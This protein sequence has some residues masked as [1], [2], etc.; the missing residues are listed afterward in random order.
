M[1]ILDR[2]IGYRVARGY[3]LVMAICVAVRS[4]L[5]LVEEL[6]QVGNGQYTLREVFLFIVLMLPSWI[7]EL[8]PVTALLGGLIGLGELAGGRELVAMQTSGVSPLRIGWSVLRAGGLLLLAAMGLQEFVAPPMQQLALTRQTQA[9]SGTDAVRT[10]QGFWSRDGR[11]VM[12][13]RRILHGQIPSD[14]DIYQF[15]EQRRLRLF[16]HARW[17]ETADSNR[18]LLI[19][20]E[21]RIFGEEEITSRVLP[22]LPWESFLTPEQLGILVLPI[23]SLSPSDIY[24]YIHHLRDSG[25]NADR[26]EHSLWQKASLPVAAGAMV[27]VSIPFVFG[28]LRTATAGKRILA[29]AIAGIGFHLGAQIIGHFAVTF[30]LGPALATMT[31]PLAAIGI[32]VWLFRRIT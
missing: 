5:A 10:A 4:I 18:W 14:I 16:T 26:H 21:Q 17:A 20:V 30:N 12:N 1:N 11:H 32:A 22:N 31:P 2:H 15:D 24:Q 7:V 19:D 3:L 25:Q 9:I 23:E 29:G 8:A 6:D 27:L 28:P 13:V